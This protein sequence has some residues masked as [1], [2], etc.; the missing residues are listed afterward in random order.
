[1]ISNFEVF[2]VVVVTTLNENQTMRNDLWT[3]FVALNAPTP[4]ITRVFDTVRSFSHPDFLA[5]GRE[6]KRSILFHL[7][8]INL[9][10]GFCY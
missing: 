6:K 7:F 3:R 5:D 9:E 1:M 2:F 4:K 8:F 10:L